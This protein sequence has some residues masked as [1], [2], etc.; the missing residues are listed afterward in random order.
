MAQWLVLTLL[1]EDLS[2]DLYLKGLGGHGVS[3]GG[4]RQEDPGDLLASHCS[5]NGKLH[6]D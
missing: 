6:V 3:N 4:Q 5:S 1:P 2:S